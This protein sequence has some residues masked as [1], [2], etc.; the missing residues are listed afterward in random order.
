MAIVCYKNVLMIDKSH[1][2]ALISL[3]NILLSIEHYDR[4]IKYY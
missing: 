2:Q 3:A 4:A 1:N